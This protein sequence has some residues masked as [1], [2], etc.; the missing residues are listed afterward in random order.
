MP[1][2]KRM[3]KRRPQKKKNFGRKKFQMTT[4]NRGLQPFASRY[5]TKMK[6]SDSIALSAL[7]AYQY[8]FNLNSCFDPNATG[9]GHQPYGFDQLTPIYNRYR[10]ISTKYVINA[11]NNTNAIRFG[12][13]A[14]NDGAP[15]N[16]M[17]ELAE[18]PRAQTRVQLPNGSTQS[19]IGR[20]SMPS[21]MGRTKVQYMTDD[22]YQSLVTASPAELGL[23]TIYGQTI[24]DTTTDVSVVITLE[25]TVEFFD[26]KP[27]DQ[28]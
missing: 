18:S 2:K 17:S 20:I 8:A 22:R 14:T 27:I 19:I 25:Y 10:V 16:N 28:S 11:Y 4:V 24:N 7:N 1:V 12:C 26:P 21:L 9:L 6:Y 3:V 23:L 5:I 15:I 13:I